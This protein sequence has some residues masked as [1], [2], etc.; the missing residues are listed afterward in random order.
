MLSQTIGNIRELATI[1]RKS[2]DDGSKLADELE[3][4]YGYALEG[5]DIAESHADEMAQLT[6]LM[7]NLDVFLQGD[8]KMLL[9][10]LQVADPAIMK[11]AAGKL[12]SERLILLQQALNEA[13]S[14]FEA[15]KE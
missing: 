4:I 11:E 13:V 1:L 15:R 5:R 12:S 6:T 9:H 3:V 2:A 8:P 14:E 10:V 7:V